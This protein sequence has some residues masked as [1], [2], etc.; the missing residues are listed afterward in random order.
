VNLDSI[1]AQIPEWAGADDLK[2]QLIGGLTNTNY[3][4][5]VNNQ[6]FVLRISGK[7]TSILGINRKAELETMEIA[8]AHGLGPEVVYFIQPEGHLVTRFIQGR[9][10]TYNEYCQPANLRIIVEAVKTIHQLPAIEN[11]ASPFRR[12][13][14]YLRHTKKL[15]VSYPEGFDHAIVQ[16]RELEAGLKKDAFPARGLCHNDLFSLNFID[17][18]RVRFIDWEFAGMGDIF[19]DLATLVYTFDSVGEISPELQDT[20]LEC[21][22]GEVNE[23][24]RNRLRQMKFMVLLFSVLWGLLQYGLQNAGIIPLIDGFDCRSYAHSMFNLIQESK[25]L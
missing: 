17:D 7:N 6:E 13:E 19:Y 11:E 9:H 14:H 8:A 16:M 15:D 20:I 18:G 23:Y 1:I 3:K 2:I 21:Y 22:F 4:I 24:L 5:E 10:W 12:I 25:F